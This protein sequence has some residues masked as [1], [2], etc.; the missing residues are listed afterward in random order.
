MPQYFDKDGN[1]V[2]AFTAEEV[3]AR[4]KA[5]AEAAVKDNPQL[6]TLQEQLD[7]TKKELE[8][9]K[10][11][12]LNFA[13]LKQSKEETEKKVKELQEQITAVEQGSVKQ[14]KSDVFDLL[15]DGDKD[16]REKLE[17]EYET[18]RGDPKTRD[19]IISQAKKALSIVKPT[20]VPGAFDAFNIG[21]GRPP[22]SGGDK[23][24]EFVP[25]PELKQVANN[26]GISDEDFKK[27][28]GQIK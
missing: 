11:K 23:G 27:Y 18:F 5:A 15:S 8:G 14:M 25:S 6:K 9:F 3:T 21:G 24:K 16:V 7:A 10:D 26:L 22:V 4:E 2:E 1:E 19:E 20:A 28:G 17:K 13:N 12:D